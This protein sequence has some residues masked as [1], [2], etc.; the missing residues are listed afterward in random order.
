MN[1]ISDTIP[2]MAYF[3]GIDYSVLIVM[4]SFSL[5]IG[6]YFAFFSK[7][8]KTVDDYLVGGHQ[9]KSIPIAISLVAR[10]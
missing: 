3:T 6:I 9:M 1:N 10:Y 8:L 4:L 7:K 5:S 2:E